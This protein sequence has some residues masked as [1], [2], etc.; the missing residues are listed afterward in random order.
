MR[1]A[2]MRCSVG[3]AV[4]AR[5]LRNRCVSS[6]PRPALP[7]PS[8][9]PS[10]TLTVQCWDNIIGQNTQWVAKTGWG[11]LGGASVLAVLAMGTEFNPK[12][13]AKKADA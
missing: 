7:P 12:K 5:L 8:S 11:A 10:L 3:V 2:A 4:I 1:C 9:V 6:P 13:A